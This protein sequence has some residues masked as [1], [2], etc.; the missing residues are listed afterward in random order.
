MGRDAVGRWWEGLMVD[1]GVEKENEE[2][3]HLEGRYYPGDWTRGDYPVGRFANAEGP[4]SSDW[5]PGHG[6]TSQDELCCNGGSLPHSVENSGARR[7]AGGDGGIRGKD[8]VRGH[9]AGVSVQTNPWVGQI[10][11]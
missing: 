8:G 6:M 2:D 10:W 7:V 5:A 3:G 1:D 11:H 4:R 9:D